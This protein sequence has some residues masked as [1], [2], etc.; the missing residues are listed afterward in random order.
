MMR[1][2]LQSKCWRAAGLRGGF[3]MGD[4]T[5]NEALNDE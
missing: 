2:V 1:S 3:I 4:G 5:A